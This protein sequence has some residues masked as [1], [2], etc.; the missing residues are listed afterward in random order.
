MCLCADDYAWMTRRLLQTLGGSSQARV[1]FFLEG[2]YDRQAL[3]T[4]VQSTTDALFS[5]VSDAVARRPIHPRHAAE[6]AAVEKVQRAFW[7]SS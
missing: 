3:T 1:G 2:G 5:S 7:R 4:S 6:L